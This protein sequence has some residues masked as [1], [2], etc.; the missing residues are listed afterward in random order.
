MSYTIIRN[1]KFVTDRNL[2]TLDEIIDDIEE[3]IQKVKKSW[4]S[5]KEECIKTILYEYGNECIDLENCRKRHDVST[6]D[7]CNEA[8][9]DCF[10]ISEKNAGLCASCG[11]DFYF[12]DE[13]D[14][15]SCSY[16]E[17]HWITIAKLEERK[18]DLLQIKEFIDSFEGK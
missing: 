10:I 16:G 15:Y 1:G 13:A 14:D 12:D 8:T 6:C 4:S 11:T 7:A 17:N 18:R 2:N 9:S 5:Q 3:A